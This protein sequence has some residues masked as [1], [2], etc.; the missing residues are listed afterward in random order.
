MVA[1][2]VLPRVL[3]LIAKLA[4]HVVIWELG[5]IRALVGSWSNTGEG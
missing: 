2:I 3:R 4:E 1:I 5:G